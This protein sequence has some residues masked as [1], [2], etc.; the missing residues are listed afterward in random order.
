PEAF[1]LW[2]FIDPAGKP[3]PPVPLVGAKAVAVGGQAPPPP[4]RYEY[5][6]LAPDG[7][8]LVAF[9]SG[10]GAPTG[11]VDL[12][13]ARPCASGK[14]LKR[15]ASRGKLPAGAC[16]GLQFIKGGRVAVL[17]IPAAQQ[18]GQAVVIWDP[19]KDSVSEPV[20]VPLGVR[21]GQHQT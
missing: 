18:D 3:P 20:T 17:I 7:A 2:S 1:C 5:F 15:I 4:E 19:V 14:E 9:R 6:V 8:Q 12:F 16:A 21:Q 13:E 10:G 11:A